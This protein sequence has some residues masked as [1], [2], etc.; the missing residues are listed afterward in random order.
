[1]APKKQHSKAEGG[2]KKENN[3]GGGNKAKEDD[4]CA[5]MP[6]LEDMRK[7][8]A[9]GA[10]KEKEK[11]KKEIKLPEPRWSQGQASRRVTFPEKEVQEAYRLLGIEPTL[12]NDELYSILDEKSQRMV[13]TFLS[14][15]RLLPLTDD[16]NV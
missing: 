9:T 12:T 8:N 16:S 3:K 4:E 2:K 1:M 6:P 15:V 10:V 13:S 14:V 5:D 11:G 7:I